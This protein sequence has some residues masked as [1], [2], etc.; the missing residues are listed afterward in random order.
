MFEKFK[1]K[2]LFFGADPSLALHALGMTTGLVVGMGHGVSY[3]A[4]VIQGLSF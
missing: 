4:P 2:K 1:V 3:S